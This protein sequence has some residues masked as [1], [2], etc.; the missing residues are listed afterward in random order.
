MG[1]VSSG[2]GRA[3]RESMSLVFDDVSESVVIIAQVRSP[4]CLLL[5]ILSQACAR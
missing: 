3:G 2:D 5:M 1:S 4:V